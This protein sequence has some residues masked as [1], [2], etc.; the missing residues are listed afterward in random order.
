MT[1]MTTGKWSTIGNLRLFVKA[2]AVLEINHIER[3]RGFAVLR[4]DGYSLHWVAPGGAT[5]HGTGNSFNDAV[6][7]VLQ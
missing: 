7:W 2:G 5:N 1:D 6:H 3:G 4:D